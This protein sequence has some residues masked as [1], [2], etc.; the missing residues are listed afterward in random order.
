MEDDFGKNFAIAY[1]QAIRDIAILN[2]RS[3]RI[4]SGEETPEDEEEL[5]FA[6][7]NLVDEYRKDDP[8]RALHLAEEAYKIGAR[9]GFISEHNR[10][11]LTHEIAQLKE[12][13]RNPR[14]KRLWW[15]FW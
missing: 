14:G 8:K 6:H 9:N 7:I 1:K 5:F 15:K 11:M 10:N 3:E 4:V 2:E 13:I 12:S